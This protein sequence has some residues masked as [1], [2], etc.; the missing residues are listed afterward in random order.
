MWKIPKDKLIDWLM[1]GVFIMWVLS[2]DFTRMT[3]FS[4]LAGGSMLIYLIFFT[5]KRINSK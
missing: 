4:W 3:G 5:F 1:V 2:T